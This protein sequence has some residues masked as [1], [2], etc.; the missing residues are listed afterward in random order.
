M[1]EKQCNQYES[2]ICGGKIKVY[3]YS[4]EVGYAGALGDLVAAG[5]CTEADYQAFNA[6]REARPR[7]S[8]HVP[9]RHGGNLHFTRYKDGTVGAYVDFTGPKGRARDA[10]SS[11]HDLQHLRP[12]SEKAIETIDRHQACVDRCL[13]DVKANK[14]LR[15]FLDSVTAEG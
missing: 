4:R 15:H 6:K 10:L 2:T 5:I 3:T 7:G 12:T 8:C 1:A 9:Y 11:L 13:R 14:A